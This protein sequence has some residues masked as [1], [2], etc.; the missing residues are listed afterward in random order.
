MKKILFAIAIISFL[1]T[2]ISA[3]PYDNLL[4]AIRHGDWEAIQSRWQKCAKTTN[5]N[6]MLPDGS[7]LLHLIAKAG[8]VEIAEIVLGFGANPD[9]GDASDCTPL[10]YASQ[11]KDAPM[12]QILIGP[13]TAPRSPSI[14]KAQ[15]TRELVLAS[16]LRV[17]CME[18]EPPSESAELPRTT[19]KEKMK[20]MLRRLSI[21]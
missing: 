14:V 20:Q 1:S 11:N 13:D 3:N 7:T 19:K 16:Q 12:M 6:A 5:V 21:S 15:E 17:V 10:Y 18:E 4:L 2:N 9:F 8:R